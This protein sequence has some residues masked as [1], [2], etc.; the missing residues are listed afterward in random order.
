MKD[1]HWCGLSSHSPKSCIYRLIGDSKLAIG[2]SVKVVF[3]CHVINLLINDNKSSI[4]V[5]IKK[6]F[7][8]L[9]RS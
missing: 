6:T 4:D 9:I 7:I 2:V 8:R 5:M 3:V 1:G